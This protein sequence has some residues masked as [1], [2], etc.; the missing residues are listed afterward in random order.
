MSEHDPVPDKTISRDGTP[1]GFWRSG[2][3][4]AL[5][6]VHGTTA[7]HTRWETVLPLLEPHVTVYAM[8]RRGR[9]ASG[10]GSVYTL[11]AEA[12]DVAAV[13]DAVAESTGGP[14]DVLGHSYGAL[15][16]LEATALTAGMRRLVLYEPPLGAV[17]PPGFADRVD[18]LV[19]RGR[20]DEAVTTLLQFIGMS[21]EQ[22]TLAKSLPSWRGRVAAAYTIGRGRPAAIAEELHEFGSR[23]VRRLRAG[24]WAASPRRPRHRHLAEGDELLRRAAQRSAAPAARLVANVQATGRGGGHDLHYRTLQAM[25]V[26]L[27]GRLAGIERPPRPFRRRPGRLSG[28]R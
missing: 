18:D 26:Q 19:A 1:I 25:G 17:T 9:G 21:A 15:C 6:L 14:A 24:A 7:D 23:R 28:F 13:V 4:P 22:L 5:V 16:T 20:P 11:E 2:Q 3:G 12:A 10:D 27:L 8:D